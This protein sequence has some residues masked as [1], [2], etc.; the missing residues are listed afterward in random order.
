MCRHKRLWNKNQPVLDKKIK[1]QEV[2]N[3]I[4][5]HDNKFLDIKGEVNNSNSCT[6]TE[7]GNKL[8][9]IKEV[10]KRSHV[11]MQ[12]VVNESF[13]VV[14]RE[15][16]QFMESKTELKFDIFITYS[17]INGVFD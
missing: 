1:F 5:L 3:H 2:S 6:W 12:K 15:K 13:E 9:G 7:E 8:Q 10:E 17:F 11:Q 4:N 16:M 14:R